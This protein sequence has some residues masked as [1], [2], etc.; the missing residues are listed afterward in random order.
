MRR[1]I[2]FALVGACALLTT[3]ASAFEREWH[4]GVG[5]GASDFSA[6]GLGWGPELGLYG[7]YG[8]SDVFDV[9]LEGRY[10]LHPLHLGTVDD[11]RGFVEVEAALAYKI[12]VLRWV[13]WLAVG[14]G[15]FQA[16]EEP[17][18][19]QSLRSSDALVS[20]LLGLD[21]AVTRQFGLGV[22]GRS[23]MLFAGSF[24]YGAQLRAEYRW[25]F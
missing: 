8:I 25:G 24:V 23:T 6:K 7:A 16:L 21:Y 13:P 5:V 3:P 20:A 9:R 22:T 14:A 10:S 18:P 17:L 4:L 11:W 15:Y 12:D 1:G 2:V 19:D